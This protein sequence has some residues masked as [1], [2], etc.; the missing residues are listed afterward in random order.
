MKDYLL[1]QREDEVVC[2]I[3]AYDVIMLRPL[4]E[5]ENMFTAFAK[6]TSAKII[7]GCDKIQNRFI[8]TYSSWRF[9]GCQAKKLNAGT[10]IGYVKYLLPMIQEMLDHDGDLQA[11]DQKSLTKYCK[12]NSNIIHIDCDSVFFLTIANPLKSFMNSHMQFIDNKLYYNGITPFFAHG[13]ANTDMSDILALLGYYIDPDLQQQISA[14]HRRATYKKL[15]WSFPDIVVACLL[16][17][18]GIAFLVLVVMQIKKRMCR[19]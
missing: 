10:Y 1:Q 12:R 11:D 13:N 9:G 16:V 15:V 2:F 3:D 17:L 18:I 4:E 7:V 6:S 14:Y 19:K 8:A 5:L